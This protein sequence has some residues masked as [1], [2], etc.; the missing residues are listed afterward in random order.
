MKLSFLSILAIVFITL[1][2][3][4]YINWSWF[5][6]LAPIWAPISFWIALFIFAKVSLSV[7]EFFERK[8]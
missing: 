2:L 5:W 3:T 6:V 7:I 1:K 8:K 4:H